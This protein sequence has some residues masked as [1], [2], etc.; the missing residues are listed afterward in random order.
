VERPIDTGT[1]TIPAESERMSL[2][3]ALSFIQKVGEEKSLQDKIRAVG[4]G[5]DLDEIMR[6]GL[7]EGFAFTVDEL[8]SA[9]GKDWLMRRLYY[10][11]RTDERD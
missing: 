3:N 9:F 8:K 2:Q 11:G 4:K 7:E 6:I 1:S 10:R 5:V